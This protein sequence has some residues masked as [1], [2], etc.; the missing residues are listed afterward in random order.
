MMHSQ[1]HLFDL[2]KE[3]TYLNG[4]SVSPMMTQHAAIGKQGIDVKLRPYEITQPDWF[5]PVD[6]LK[7]KF[8]ELIHCDNHHR[9]ALIPSV[10]Y[11]IATVAKNIKLEKGEEILIADAQFPSNY[12]T[13]NDLAKRSGAELN[14]VAC[15]S[16][17]AEKGR[18]WN[19]QILA[20]ISDRTRVVTIGN[21]HW[22]DG[23]LFQ[24]EA[25]SKRVKEHGGLLIIDGSQSIGAMPFDIRKVQAD[26]V[27]C[28]GYKWLLGAYS[29]ALAYFGPYFDNGRPL[30]E[31]WIN[32]KGS[33]DF[34][35]LSNYTPLY[36]PYAGRYNVGQQ[37][38][39][40]LIPILTASI[41]QVL[42]WGV[43]N[44]Q[45]YSE[46]ISKPAIEVL[47]EMGCTINAEEWR[48]HHLFGIRFS[49]SVDLERLQENFKSQKVFLSLRGSAV[50]VAV[51]VYNEKRDMEKLIYCIKESIR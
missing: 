36:K 29:L 37:S 12:Y 39:F 5:E 3:I 22:A 46:S 24:L 20:A 41:Q 44:I 4:S 28:V 43:E 33:E 50:R 32:R 11:G 21:I 15:Q 51:H 9:I 48:V 40:A 6:R 34:R 45:A 14:V 25:I 38:N 31:N 1:R 13:W 7:Q 8:A 17:E 23:T 47:R 30:E 18:L 16:D 2:P 27:I 19:E 10:S 42:D 35:Q 26:A 49:S